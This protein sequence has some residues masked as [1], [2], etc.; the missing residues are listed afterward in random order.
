MLSIVCGLFVDKDE[1]EEGAASFP[2]FESL[3]GEEEEGAA[4]DV[5]FPLFESLSEPEPLFE[6]E[7]DKVADGD[8]VLSSQGIQSGLRII[9]R[10][11]FRSSTI[12]DDMRRRLRSSRRKARC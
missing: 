6:D 8:G 4:A 9:A 1:D 10:H 2:L 7:D 5:W 12:S 11:L 3:S